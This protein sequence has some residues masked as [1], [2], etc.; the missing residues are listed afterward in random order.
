MTNAHIDTLT[1]QQKQSA[2]EANDCRKEETMKQSKL[3][4][5]YERLSREDGD[6]A[7]SQSIATQKAILEKYA[8]QNGLTPYRHFSD[9]GFSGKD[10]DRP[11]FQEMLAEIEKGNIGAVC[12][13]NLDRFGRSYLE[14]GLYRESFRKM[15]VRFIAVNDAI[16]TAQ[17]EDDFTPFRE[18]INEF[19]L[20]EYS[21]KVKAAYQSR[22]MAGKPTASLP[23]YGYL[24]SVEDKHKWVKD[25]EAAEVVKRIFQLTM[26]G[27]GPYQ[28]CC[29]LEDDKVLTPGAYLKE[30]GVGLHKSYDFPNPYKWHSTTVINILKKK[31]YLGHTV[32]FKSKKN[33]YKDKKNH[34]VPESEWVIFE[35][36]H[37]AIIDPVT[38]ENVQRLRSNIKRRPDGWGYVHP[39]T[40]LVWC[41]D[42]GAKLYVHRIY[43]G[44]DM[45]VYVCGNST[46]TAR[47][48]NWHCTGHRIT[49]ER[50]MTLVAETLREVTK[51]AREDKAAFTKSVQETLTA[52]QA[53]EIKAHK[54]QLAKLTRRAADL[55]TLYKKIYE[56]SALGK[57]PEK[58]FSSLAAEYE[59]EQAGLEMQ[60]PE[61]QAAIDRF[62]DGSDRA[63]RFIELVKRYENFDDMTT[64]M[65]NEFVEKI[66]V[67]ERDAKG[68]VDTEQK[69]DIYLNFIGEYQI[70]QEPIDPALLAEQEEAN[71]KKL[72]KREKQHQKYLSLKASGK[73]AEY[74]Q[75]TKEKRAAGIPP[76]KMAR[77][78]EEKAAR[79]IARS[80]YN[81]EYG[82][83]RWAKIRAEREAQQAAAALLQTTIHE[84]KPDQSGESEVK[85]TA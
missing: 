44:K 23:P 84:I 15:G 36:T 78:P 71:R 5:L 35:N 30:K 32:N 39:L 72:A 64:A 58:M 53:D 11:A 75:R 29:I 62:N 16:D 22:G 1:P 31:E 9:D 28:I 48:F 79:D 10:F 81:K 13:K 26:D 20:R 77:T 59:S 70:P 25:P 57:L 34:Y 14:S 37:E 85:K 24:K 47:D 12:V 66:V 42:C 73:L 19:Y 40:G 80:E 54:K 27:K 6:N 7:E 18:V 51:Y 68:C 67:H 76:R 49:A 82:R 4:A 8:E 41:A 38:F 74:E 33:S 52:K 65:L 17:G 56:D 55:E 50:L 63:A 69:V 45:P 46:K 2:A 3:T 61:L 43:N 60:I 83:K 21:K